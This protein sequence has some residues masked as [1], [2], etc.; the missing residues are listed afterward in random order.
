MRFLS[1]SLHAFVLLVLV[2][3]AEVAGPE[4][5]SVVL[6]AQARPP[7]A[8]VKYQTRLGT[9]PAR[10]THGQRSYHHT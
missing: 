4:L 2:V 8:D 5:L 10:M 3:D 6:H 9:P 1:L 7:R